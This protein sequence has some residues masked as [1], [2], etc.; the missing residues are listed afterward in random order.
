MLSLSVALFHV[1]WKQRVLFWPTLSKIVR[2]LMQRFS[3]SLAPHSF[4]R[5]ELL[6]EIFCWHFYSCLL[7]WFYFVYRLLLHPLYWYFVVYLML[8]LDRP[9]IP[10]GPKNE[11]TLHFAEYLENYQTYLHDFCTHQD[12]CILNMYAHSRFTNFILYSGAI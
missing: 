1:C 2:H 5:C 3:A 4:T 8:P 6:V 11:A 7:L 9:S 12:E 10:G